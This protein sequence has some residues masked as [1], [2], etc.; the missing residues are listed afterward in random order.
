MLMHCVAAAVGDVCGVLLVS[1]LPATGAVQ[2]LALSVPP[3]VP[4]WEAWPGLGSPARCS[5]ACTSPAN[6]GSFMSNAEAILWLCE[7]V[8]LMLCN[9]KTKCF[10]LIINSYSVGTDSLQGH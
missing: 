4:I 8:L 9:L 6:L 2:R 3:C 1:L 10:L 7:I 5:P